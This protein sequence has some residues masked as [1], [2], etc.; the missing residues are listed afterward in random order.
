MLQ[1]IKTK[2]MDIAILTLLVSGL[3]WGGITHNK[4]ET[5]KEANIELHIEL[6]KKQTQFDKIDTKLD[7]ILSTMSTNHSDV[8]S[9]LA[10]I[11]DRLNI[12][13]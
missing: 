6:D 13:K 4:V 10:V 12:K 9:R 11:E 2:I 7:N 8:N 1:F 5:L 3:I